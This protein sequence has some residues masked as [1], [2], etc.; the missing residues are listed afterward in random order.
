VLAVV[1][2]FLGVARSLPAV[3]DLRV[4]TTVEYAVAVAAAVG[5][6]LV[7]LS[8]WCCWLVHLMRLV[9]VLLLLLQLAWHPFQ[10][11][12]C[13][14]LVAAAPDAEQTASGATSTFPAIPSDLHH[15]SSCCV[16]TPASALDR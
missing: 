7:L 11:G 6:V 3:A 16:G 4:L 13:S 1:V 8:S 10:R 12:A 5:V 14:L 15:P 2:V 9:S